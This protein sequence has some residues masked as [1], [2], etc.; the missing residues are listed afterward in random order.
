MSD[1]NE[2]CGTRH[3]RWA[4]APVDVL[5]PH[6]RQRGLL[7]HQAAAALIAILLPPACHSLCNSR[8][9]HPHQLLLVLDS[10]VRDPSSIEPFA[11]LLHAHLAE[12]L[13]DD[14]AILSELHC[15]PIRQRPHR[16]ALE[17]LDH[18]VPDHLD[19]VMVEHALRQHFARPEGVPAVDDGHALG[20]ARQD[21]GIFHGGVAA[22]DHHHLL[23]R[24]QEA[25]TRRARAH[26]SSPEVVLALGAQPA[27]VGA[28]RQHH[29][30]RLDAGV[31]GG[32]SEGALRQVHLGDEVLLEDGAVARCLALHRLHQRRA[33]ALVHAWVVFDADAL[34]LELP[35]DGRRHNDRPQP[36]ARGIDGSGEACRA[37]AD[38]HQLL[39]LRPLLLGVDRKV[40]EVVI[41]IGGCLLPLLLL[42]LLPPLE[43]L[44]ELLHAG[45]V[46][47]WLRGLRLAALGGG[48]RG[49]RLRLAVS[50]GSALH[51]PGA[52]LG[53]L[54]VVLLLQRFDQCVVPRTPALASLGDDFLEF[55]VVHLHQLLWR[56]LLVEGLKRVDSHFD[57]LLLRLPH[58]LL[59][60]ALDAVG[61]SAREL[62]ALLP[63]QEHLERRHAPDSLLR[64]DVM[65]VVDVNLGED[66][67]VL[68]LLG[69]LLEVRRNHAARTAAI[70][71]KVDD[72]RQPRHIR[73][74]FQQ[75]L[76]L[77]VTL[78]I[79]D[80][81]TR[82]D[83]RSKCC[84]DDEHK[85]TTGD[86]TAS[87]RLAGCHG[88]N[89]AAQNARSKQR[90]DDT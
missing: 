86:D 49:C 48:R 54:A 89:Q 45:Q 67:L 12:V 33:R 65:V 77:G 81:R 63:E 59:R 9:Q 4:L 47:V 51:R 32:N 76:E 70:A 68:V 80:C 50:G 58:Q 66:G 40:A 16:D 34:A 21:E 1:G 64:G 25:I 10:R 46:Q 84:Q 83:I 14:R 6:A 31:V 57:V 29:R 79:A 71:V 62:V 20:G 18:S 37:G 61:V 69:Q 23:P 7:L 27:R 13:L 85:D 73:V 82:F 43:L 15:Q 11:D 60:H 52:G 3:L 24:V 74:V 8:L 36:C 39:S 53:R 22:A 56:L 42:L 38:D 35:S 28:C 75:L 87:N 2:R 26:A 88:W 30:V 5:E 78:D 44:L 90:T 19:F 41:L 72:D 17:G 55:L